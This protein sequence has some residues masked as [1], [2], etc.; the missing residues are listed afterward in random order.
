MPQDELQRISENAVSTAHKL[1]DERVAK[2][3]LNH[4][5]TICAKA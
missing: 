3:Y 4:L 1:T 2:D 5:K